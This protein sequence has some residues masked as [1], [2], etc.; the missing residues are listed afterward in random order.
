MKISRI[1][2]GS[3]TEIHL[4]K[5]FKNGRTMGSE[6]IH[7]YLFNIHFKVILLFISTYPCVNVIQ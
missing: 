7:A 3:H 6:R 1:A 2:Y 4:L 5:L